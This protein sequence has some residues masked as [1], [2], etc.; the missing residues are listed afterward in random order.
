MTIAETVLE[1][2]AVRTKTTTIWLWFLIIIDLGLAGV[3]FWGLVFSPVA[4][5]I[6]RYP[7]LFTIDVIILILSTLNAVGVFL[8]L[9]WKKIGFNIVIG[10][11]ALDV[12]FSLIFHGN[13]FYAFSLAFF[14]ICILYYVLQYPKS[15]RAW[16]H[17]T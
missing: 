8:I 10:C 12:F 4:M 13:I 15:N 5:Y 2:P 16:D 6:T 14:N 11:A 1:K 3:L 7:T 17:L 9:K